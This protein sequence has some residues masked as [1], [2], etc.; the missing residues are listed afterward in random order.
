MQSPSEPSFKATHVHAFELLGEDTVRSQDEAQPS[1]VLGWQG[2]EPNGCAQ[3]CHG[4]T[5]THDGHADSG[6]GHR[7]VGA[8]LQKRDLGSADHVHN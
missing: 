6:N 3:R 4:D 8:A 2:N 5:K 7:R 1:V